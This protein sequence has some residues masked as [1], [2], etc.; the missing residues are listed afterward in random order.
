MWDKEFPKPIMMHILRA[1]IA[2]DFHH[3]EERN[4]GLEH[5]CSPTINRKNETILFAFTKSLSKLS[6][7]VP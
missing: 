3:T 6:I 5:E 4:F 1:K 2:L 7:Q